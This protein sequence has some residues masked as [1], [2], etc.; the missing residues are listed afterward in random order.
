MQKSF[1]WVSV[2]LSAA[3][4]GAL[5]IS[6]SIS[7]GLADDY[8]RLDGRGR[9]RAKVNVIE[10][11]DNLEIHVYPAGA[12]Q[13]LAL[14]LDDAK[15]GGKVMVIGYRFKTNPKEQLIRRAILGIPIAEGFK[16]YQDPQSGAEYDKWIVTN[17]APEKAFVSYALETPPTQL[18]PDGH[19]A[20][21]ERSETASPARSAQTPSTPSRRQPASGV[22]EDTGAIRSKSW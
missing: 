15:H 20:L 10:W 8:D 18:Y 19:P 5:S 1:V 2:L 17:G 9:S 3:T 13:G 11:K 16:V 21:A 7:W 22:D 4:M 6:S 14:Q 12:L